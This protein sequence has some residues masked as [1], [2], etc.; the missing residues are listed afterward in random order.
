[1]TDGVRH[2]RRDGVS[3]KTSRG[4]QWETTSLDFPRQSQWLK[5]KAQRW[6]AWSRLTFGRKADNLQRP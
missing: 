1:M 4:R 5:E 2:R 6:E 3:I